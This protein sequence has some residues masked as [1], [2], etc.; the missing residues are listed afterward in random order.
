MRRN[1]E[2]IC[3]IIYQYRVERF[4][5][6]ERKGKKQGPNCSIIQEA[7]GQVPYSTKEATSEAVKKGSER[8]KGADIKLRLA[9][10]RRAEKLQK[11][12]KK[13]EQTKTQFFIDPF[14]FLTSLFTREKSGA[15]KVTKKDLEDHLKMIH[16][17]PRWHRQLSVPSDIPPINSP[18]H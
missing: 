12:R 17:D 6:E 10:L 1:W 9:S 11:C 5:V 13:K 14:K 18:E 8:K 7:G 3:D 16:S 15:L 4:G 2:K